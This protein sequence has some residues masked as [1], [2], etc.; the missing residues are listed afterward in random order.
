[1]WYHVHLTITPQGQS[2]PFSHWEP[3][4]LV[5]VSPSARPGAEHL[6]DDDADD[7]EVGENEELR[8]WDV[9]EWQEDEEGKYAGAQRLR[10]LVGL[11]PEVR[12]FRLRYYFEILGEVRVTAAAP[13]PS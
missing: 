7:D 1:M 11:Q 2:A 3:G 10:L 5:L 9:Q 8:I 6:L 13:L 4:E 12:E